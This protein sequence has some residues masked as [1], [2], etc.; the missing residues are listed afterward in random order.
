MGACQSG[1]RGNWVL[2]R[3]L[4]PGGQSTDAL[5]A[6]TKTLIPCLTMSQ[7]M[8]EVLFPEP[9]LLHERHVVRQEVFRGNSQVEKGLEAIHVIGRSGKRSRVCPGGTEALWL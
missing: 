5:R 3:T 9:G 1:A 4:G 8:C 2:P 7:A 6:K